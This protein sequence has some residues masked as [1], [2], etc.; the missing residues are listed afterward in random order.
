MLRSLWVSTTFAVPLHL[1]K[2]MDKVWA[3]LVCVCLFWCHAATF[4]N[5]WLGLYWIILGYIRLCD[6]AKWSFWLTYNVWNP[7]K[8]VVCHPIK[9]SHWLTVLPNTRKC[10]QLP[11][12]C[13]LDGRYS[14]YY[15]PQPFQVWLHKLSLNIKSNNIL[16]KS[17]N[18]QFLLKWV[19]TCLVVTQYRKK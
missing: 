2:I 6:G 12:C 4:K 5:G 15:Y 1:K 17:P 3:Q 8:P 18:S 14:L 10:T 13:Q 9:I 16:V 7:V 19:L 11:H